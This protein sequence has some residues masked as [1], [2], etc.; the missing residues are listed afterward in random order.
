M[1]SRDA[2]VT[3]TCGRVAAL[4]RHLSP[5]RVN[6]VICY[7]GDCQAYARHLQRSDILNSRGG[8]DI[9]Q[10]PA[11]QFRIV[12]GGERIVGLKM[13]ARPT[14]RWYARCCH[15]PIAN[16]SSPQSPAL[17]VLAASF[18]DYGS[19]LGTLVGAPIGE[20]HGQDAIGE[21]PPIGSGIGISVLL[22]AVPKVLFWKLTGQGRP[23]PF[24]KDDTTDLRYPLAQ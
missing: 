23:N 12:S 20:I 14:I 21:G 8:S 2:R 7:C 15:A 6:R 1:R 17:G 13:T 11:G 24:C 22:R 18:A 16:M 5:G 19:A 9:I 10:L 3:C 4:A